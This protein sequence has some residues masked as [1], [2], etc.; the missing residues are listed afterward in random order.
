[1]NGKVASDGSVSRIQA[2]ETK[3]KDEGNFK[4]I[5]WVNRT[6]NDSGLWNFFRPHHREIT[7]FFLWL[8]ESLGLGWLS[9]K[10]IAPCLSVLFNYETRG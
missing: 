8:S 4:R 10:L 1:M 9:F 6:D 3:Y 5:L 2:G 7:L